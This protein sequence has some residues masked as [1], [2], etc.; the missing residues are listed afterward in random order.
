[1]EKV[2]TNWLQQ[3]DALKEVPTDQLQWF[4][5]NS[6]CYVLQEGEFLFRSGDPVTGTHIIVNGKI[7]I[8][9]QQNK[10][11]R[12]IGFFDPGDITGYLPFSRGKVSGAFGQVVEAAQVITFPRE[13]MR[14]MNLHHFE[15]TQALVH[16]MTSR[17]REFTQI[18]QQNEKMMALGKLSA[19]LAHELNNP[20][21][22][23]VRGSASL[24]SHLQL[25][26]DTFKKVICIRM[27]DIQ[28][29]A[30]N[31]KM[32][33]ALD[34]KERP[35]LSLMEKTDLEDALTDW[36]DQKEIHKSMELAENFA[37]FN[38][39]VADLQEIEQEAGIYSL[40]PVLEWMSNVLVTEKMV[41]D[42][43]EASH[44]IS[45]L[46]NSVKNFTHMDRAGDK[47]YADIHSGLR[48]TL[49]ML[50][51]KLKK[52]NIEVVE[53][54]DLSLP[55][56]KAMVGELN[57]VWTNL[58]DNAI[59]AM[60]PN[61]K[62]KLE[63][64]TEKSGEFVKVTIIDDGTGIPPEMIS[65]VF[66]PFFTTKDMGKGT[67]LGLDVVLRI[68]NQHNGVVKCRSVA[69]KTEFEVCFLI[70]G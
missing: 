46:V 48:N 52:G 30:I 40:E 1:M 10:G 51:Y 53:N 2:D 28:V 6:D 43:Q 29:D 60:E 9:F 23:I 3:I 13:K 4:L 12:E 61:G 26:P 8:Y 17:V 41:L 25:L 59:D 65:R 66:E 20:A 16:V 18:E 19:G 11:A 22:A 54:F 42:I 38:F 34:K 27:D 56:V 36:L 68:V 50:N 33:E 24:R 62:G 45:E 14:E 63:I 49:N 69:G 44:R 55:E 31:K 15:L 64:R 47:Q 39:S 37:E 57:Q 35:V 67:G 70:H 5:D 58:I 21:A 32:F 7:R